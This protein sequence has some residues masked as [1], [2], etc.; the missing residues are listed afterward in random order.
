MGRVGGES[1]L[2]AWGGWGGQRWPLYGMG[3][4]GGESHLMAWGGWGGGS[5]GH[6]M[7]WGVKVERAT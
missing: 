7:A 2:M 6:C 4:V 5:G 1:H 3:R